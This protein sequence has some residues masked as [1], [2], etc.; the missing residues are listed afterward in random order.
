VEDRISELED[1][2]DVAEKLDEE[3]RM[4][5][6]QQNMQELWGSIKRPKLWMMCIEE[7]VHVKGIGNISNKVIA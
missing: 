7:E 4:N 5:K 1:K 6:W 2:I 3:K